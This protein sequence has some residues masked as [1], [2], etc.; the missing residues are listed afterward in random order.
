MRP[1]ALLL[2]AA[3]AAPAAAP[4]AEDAEAVARVDG[5]EITVPMLDAYVRERTQGRAGYAQLPPAQRRQALDDLVNLVLLAAEARAQ[6]LDRAPGTAARLFVREAD[7]LARAML[8]R[9]IAASPVSEEA[10]RR[11]YE[12]RFAGR[13]ETEYRLRHI[14]V[15]DEAR[16]REALRRLDAGEDFAAVARALSLDPSGEQGGDLG[17]LSPAALEPALRA[18][19]ERLAPGGRTTEP[20]R[21]RFG[22]HIVRLEGRRTAP[23]P[24]FEAVR[25]RLAAELQTERL[26]AHVAELRSKARIEERGAGR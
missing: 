18:A 15:A 14:L 24:P 19:V 21:T 2:A 22:L 26:K 1:A 16:A 10:L 20:V 7:T 3:L 23:P 4:A 25:S 8:A 5:T 9:V 17:W 11:A 6:G 13:G 12:E